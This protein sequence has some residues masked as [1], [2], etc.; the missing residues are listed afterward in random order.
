MGEATSHLHGNSILAKASR[1]DVEAEM[2]YF[3]LPVDVATS[4]RNS[5]ASDASSS[6]GLSLLFPEGEGEA[7][8]LSLILL[9]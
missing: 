9:V 1:G 7:D 4:V 2:A 6:M 3:S 8:E 5:L